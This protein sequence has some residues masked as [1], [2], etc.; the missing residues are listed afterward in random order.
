MSEPHLTLTPD[1]FEREVLQSDQPVLVDFTA[2]WCGPCRA[3]TPVVHTLAREYAG[4]V[5]VA[6]I[7]VDEAGDLGARYGVTSVPTFLV[8]KDGEVVD[9]AVGLLPKPAL[10][11]RLD[12]AA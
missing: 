9:R 8:F 6:V 5:K 7:D 12:A 4:R 11:R 1:A 2:S 10:A 3:M